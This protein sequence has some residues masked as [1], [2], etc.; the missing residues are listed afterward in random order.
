MNRDFKDR[1]GSKCRHHNDGRRNDSLNVLVI[2]E[3]WLFSFPHNLIST[4]TVPMIRVLQ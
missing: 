2:R 4:T 3:T 1:Y